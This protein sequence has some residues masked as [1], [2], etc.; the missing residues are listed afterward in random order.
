MTSKPQRAG[1]P[2]RSRSRSRSARADQGESAPGIRPDLPERRRLLP[3]DEDARGSFYDVVDDGF[4]LVGFQ[5]AGDLR[6]QP[7]EEPE[8]AAG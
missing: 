1:H 6:E 8:I 4:E 3:D 5:D 2:R 7:L